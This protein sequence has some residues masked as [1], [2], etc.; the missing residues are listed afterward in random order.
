MRR[1]ISICMGLLLA[2]VL[3]GCELETMPAPQ[4]RSGDQLN[5]SG[6]IWTV[7]GGTELFGPGPNY[8]SKDLYSAYVDDR[9]YLHLNIRKLDDGRWYCSEIISNDVVGYGRYVWVVES[10]MVNIPNNTVLGLFTWDNNTFAAQANSEVDIEFSRWGV[11]NDPKTLHMSVQPVWFG[12]F[13]PERTR[14]FQMPAQAATT[15]TTHEFV[16]TDSLISWKSWL[17]SDTAAAPMASWSFNRNNPPRVKEEGGNTSAP[18]VIPAPGPT[19]NA[20]INL[21]LVTGQAT[22]PSTGD[23]YEIVLRSFSYTPF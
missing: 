12:P 9:G 20:R 4:G 10:D 7:K 14:G 11:A 15:H 8:F 2:V 21:W 19:T 1:S 3:S 13:K 23:D 18:I 6:R 17:G 5:F 16:W 22:G